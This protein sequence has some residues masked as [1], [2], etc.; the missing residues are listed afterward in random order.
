M[1]SQ[2]IYTQ[3]VAQMMMN[4]EERLIALE[5]KWSDTQAAPEQPTTPAAG[6]ETGGTWTA[7]ALLIARDAAIAK[8]ARER[9]IGECL[10]AIQ[11][12]TVHMD[13]GG[14]TL[15]NACQAL[16]TLANKEQQ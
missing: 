14:Q 5:S 16:R 13:S 1:S 10:H 6:E 3:L 9:A 7:S 15:F 4:H 12:A 2:P 8:A 11:H